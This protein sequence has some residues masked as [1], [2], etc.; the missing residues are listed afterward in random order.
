MKTSSK[1][2]NGATRYAGF[3]FYYWS[4][5]VFLSVR[6]SLLDQ[7]MCFTMWWY[8]KQLQYQN[9][10]IFS[11]NGVSQILSK[12]ETTQLEV[13]EQALHVFC[14]R[15]RTIDGN[16]VALAD[17]SHLWS[18]SAEPLTKLRRICCWD[19]KIHCGRKYSF[20]TWHLNTNYILPLFFKLSFL[21]VIS[22][23]RRW[24]DSLCFHQ[25]FNLI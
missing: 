10:M 23:L 9:K 12:M 3:M 17:V 5:Q 18:R 25:P 14:Y 13:V 2:L 8:K 21:Y 6:P 19:F 22:N 15:A 16:D 24:N 7:D 1:R 20:Q 4:S 11:T